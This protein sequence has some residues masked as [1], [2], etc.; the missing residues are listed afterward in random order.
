MIR[1]LLLVTNADPQFYGKCVPR[2]ARKRYSL[3][4][5]VEGCV[6]IGASR[7]LLVTSQVESR[8]PDIANREFLRSCVRD[9]STPGH[10]C[11]ADI[12]LFAYPA[13]HWGGG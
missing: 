11:T 3:A 13:T 5:W 12:M 6:E 9:V 10:I 2:R 1:I 8:K 7:T 4:G